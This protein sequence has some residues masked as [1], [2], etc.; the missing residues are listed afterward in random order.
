MGL[1]SLWAEKEAAQDHLSF[2]AAAMQR[3]NE[4][5]DGVWQAI[6]DSLRETGIDL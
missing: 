4:L 3:L 2:D 1:S 6:S 5:A